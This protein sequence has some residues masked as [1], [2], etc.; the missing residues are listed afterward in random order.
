[1]AFDEKVDMLLIFGECHKNKR[2]AANVYAA[3]YPDRPHPSCSAFSR[4]EKK[5][6]FTGSLATRKRQRAKRV[7]NEEAEIDVLAALYDR[8]Q[9][10]TREI[11]NE[12]GV[13]QTSIINILKRQ[14]FH[15]FKI[16]LHQEL[17]D[18]DFHRRLQLCNWLLLEI[19]NNPMFL[20][21]ILFSDEATFV[22][23]GEMNRHNMHYWSATNPHWMRTVDHQR[24]WSLNVWCGILGNKI[25]GPHF[26]EGT[27]NGPR[28]AEFIRETLPVLLDE[29]PIETLNTM[30]FQQDGAP[31]HYAHA[32][33][34]AVSERFEERWIGRGGPVAWPPRSPDLTPL[35]FFLW[36]AIKDKVYRTPPTTP[37]DMRE[38]I[39][40]ECSS[41]GEDVLI[42]VRRAHVQ[43]LTKCIEAEGRH[44]EHLI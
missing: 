38:R 1:M 25:I 37:E 15:P 2:D 30:W 17:L 35:D 36:G 10:S 20:G 28:Y 26:F 27:L 8:P 12:L 21:M 5:A 24:R 23:T 11:S 32:A 6:R 43:R 13:S 40:N 42:R 22:N 14:K 41:I 44:F 18:A 29:V 34:N 3:R 39:R 4:L 33:R 16:S 7:T 31:P 19:E 9:M